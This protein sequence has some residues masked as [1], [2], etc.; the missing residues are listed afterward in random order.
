MKIENTA[1]PKALE[2]FERGMKALFKVLKL[3]IVQAK[4]GT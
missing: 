2:N 4:K 1:G 3:D